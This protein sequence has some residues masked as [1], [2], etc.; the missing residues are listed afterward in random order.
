M[1]LRWYSAMGAPK[2]WP[3]DPSTVTMAS[4]MERFSSLDALPTTAR[5]TPNPVPAIPN[6]TKIDQNWCPSGVTA[7]ELMTKPTE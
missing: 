3:K 1:K 2:T 7:T 6:P 5:M 4:D